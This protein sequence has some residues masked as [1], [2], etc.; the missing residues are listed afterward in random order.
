MDSLGR[1]GYEPLL[2]LA[3]GRPVGVQIRRMLALDRVEEVA[4][5]STWGARQLAEFDSG[6]TVT[7][8]LH[9]VDYDATVPLHVDVL[10]DTV[11]GARGRIA[12]LPRRLRERTPDRPVPPIMLEVNPAMLSAVGPRA[13]AQGTAELRAGGFGIGLD[14]VGTGFGLDLVARLGPD[15]VTIEQSVVERLPWDRRAAVVTRSVLEVC[16][17]VGARVAATGVTS[18]D[19]LAALREVGI[20]WAQGPLFGALRRTPSTTGVLL[21]VELMPHPGEPRRLRPTADARVAPGRSATVPVFTLGGA[22]VTLPAD[23]KAEAVRQAMADHPQAGSV[24]LLDVDGRPTGFL[25]RNRFM[26]AISGPFGRALF[27]DRPAA[28]LADHPRTAG[29]DADVR[30][31]LSRC[32]AGDRER[33][34]DDV[35]LVDG[36]GICTGI[37]RV[38]DLLQEATGNPA[39]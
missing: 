6:V 20:G 27:A 12:Q 38:G 23:V 26:L 9:G 16:A 15:L 29:L 36:G 30:E 17:E 34:Y 11:V 2:N 21:P 33:S 10:A 37:V 8:V 19:E 24:V 13:L 35:V 22:A 3:T 5:S 25:D 31:T 14:G 18:V 28:T 4:R 39:A 1:F 7:S 32:L